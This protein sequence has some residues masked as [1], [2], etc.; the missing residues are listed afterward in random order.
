M[1][2]FVPLQSAKLVDFW[3][4]FVSVEIP[5]VRIESGVERV[6]EEKMGSGVVIGSPRGA[7]GFQPYAE[8]KT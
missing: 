6:L 4:A 7:C 3:S 5:Q 1:H 8:R 2:V